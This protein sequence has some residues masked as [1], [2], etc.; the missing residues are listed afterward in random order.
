MGYDQ[1]HMLCD[2]EDRAMANG[3]IIDPDGGIFGHGKLAGENRDI[4][5]SQ[6]AGMLKAVCIQDGGVGS[7]RGLVSASRP[8]LARA[9]DAGS[10][11]AVSEPRGVWQGHRAA[12]PRALG[13]VD[14][15]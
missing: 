1:H 9:R 7:V 15:R 8:A 11:D 14:A 12:D 6:L 5:V 13:T 3:L 4:D 2:E 10:G